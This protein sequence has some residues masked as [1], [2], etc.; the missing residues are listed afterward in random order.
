MLLEKLSYLYVLV[1][2][3][4]L[5]NGLERK[6][7]QYMKICRD[8]KSK[9]SWCTVNPNFH[10]ILAQMKDK[11]DKRLIFNVKHGQ[12]GVELKI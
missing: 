2:M 5:H 8:F 1:L 4:W 12:L 7:K 3:Q 11:T 9:L 6:Q 10:P